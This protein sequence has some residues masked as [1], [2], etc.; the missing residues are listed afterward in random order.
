MKNELRSVIKII[1]PYD[2]GKF[3]EDLEKDGIHPSKIVQLGSNENPYKPP[4]KLIKKCAKAL[5]IV[6]RYPDPKYRKLRKKLAEYLNTNE[7]LSL[8]HISE[9]T[10]P[11]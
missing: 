11:Y 8:I 4:V 3:P 9:P 6:N 7:S 1:N 5:E 2:P 10:R